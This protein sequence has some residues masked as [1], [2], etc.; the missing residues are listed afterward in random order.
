MLSMLLAAL[1]PFTTPVTAGT[2]ATV[3][4]NMC[5]APIGW[6]KPF[7]HRYFLRNGA[8]VIFVGVE[9]GDDLGDA[10]HRA[11]EAAFERYLPTLV[12]V[13]GTS[14]TKS[15]FDWYRKDIADLA[16]QRFDTGA[17]GENLYAVQL[18]T[19]RGIPFLGWDFSPDQ[20]YRVLVADGVALEDAL[21]AHLLRS[22]VDPFHIEGSA[23]QIERQRRYAEQIRPI[24]SFD[25]LGWYRRNYGD[26]FDPA[27][28]TPCGPGIAG[29]IVSDLS[30]RRNLNLAALIERNAVPGATILVE[31]GGNHWLALRDWLESRSTRAE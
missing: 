19:A 13:E 7:T 21:G 27:A 12:L 22:H 10:S 28:G 8:R 25:Y 11:I 23:A 15:S 6:R 26:R 24:A 14:S 20:D 17:A 9:H 5:A 3:S 29:K 30:Y 2:D 1:F 18:A 4:R 31:A 16:R